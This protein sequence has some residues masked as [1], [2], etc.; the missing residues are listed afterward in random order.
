MGVTVYLIIVSFCLIEIV[1]KCTRATNNQNRFNM[2]YAKFLA[3]FTQRVV[4]VN[5]GGKLS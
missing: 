3:K 2:F 1:Y 5:N 4:E